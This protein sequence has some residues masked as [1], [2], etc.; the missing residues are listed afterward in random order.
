VACSTTPLG[1]FLGRNAWSFVGFKAVG[2]RGEITLD[3]F[4]PT[5]IAHRCYLISDPS[6]ADMRSRFALRVTKENV[7][8]FDF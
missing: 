7:D 4:A 2:F 5:G 8:G 6:A 1:S 3:A